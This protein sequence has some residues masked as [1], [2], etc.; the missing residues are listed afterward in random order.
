M[1]LQV[2]RLIEE[3]WKHTALNLGQ[4]ARDIRYFYNHPDAGR[5]ADE[6]SVKHVSYSM[7]RRAR[8]L[9][10]N[11]FYSAIPPH[12]HHSRKELEYMTPASAREWFLHG[13]APWRFPDPA[14]D[15]H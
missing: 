12:W 5:F 3:Y 8:S 15:R 13:Y 11:L 4:A 2:I 1:T 6:G 14:K 7:V 10:N 9:A